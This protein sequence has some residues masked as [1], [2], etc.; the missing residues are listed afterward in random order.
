MLR[1]LGE[2]ISVRFAQEGCNVVVNYLS[3]AD[4]AK[5]VAD[6]IEK[7]YGLKAFLVQGVSQ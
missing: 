4:R 6:K 5:A 7:E 1:G 2:R 3:S